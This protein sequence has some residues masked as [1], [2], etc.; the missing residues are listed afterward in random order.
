MIEDE[1]VKKSI[2]SAEVHAAY[3]QSKRDGDV[4]YEIPL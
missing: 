3:I 1:A 2:L 4:N